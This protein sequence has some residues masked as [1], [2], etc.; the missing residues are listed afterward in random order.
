MRIQEMYSSIQQPPEL[1]ELTQMKT[2]QIRQ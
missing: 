2:S 1:V